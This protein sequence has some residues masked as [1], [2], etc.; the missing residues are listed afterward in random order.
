M[1]KILELFV[2]LIALLAMLLLSPWRGIYIVVSSGGKRLT[3]SS[4]HSW[5]TVFSWIISGGLFFFSSFAKQIGIFSTGWGHKVLLCLFAIV[6]LIGLLAT[7]RDAIRWI[8][9][10][11]QS[12]VLVDEA[13]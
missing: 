13:K 2:G 3:P 11:F 6:T 12:E 4:V 7:I 5:V 10:L 9:R 1:G 8:K